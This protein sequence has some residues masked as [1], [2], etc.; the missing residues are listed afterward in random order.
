M[1][2]WNKFCENKLRIFIFKLQAI[3]DGFLLIWMWPS[4]IYPTNLL[5]QSKS[6]SKVKFHA[7]FNTEFHYIKNSPREFPFQ[8]QS[9]YFIFH[10]IF[11]ILNI[12]F[13]DSLRI[14][15]SKTSHT[16]LLAQRFYRFFSLNEPSAISN[17]NLS[18]KK[19]AFITVVTKFGSTL[20]AIFSILEVIYSLHLEK[21]DKE[22]SKCHIWHVKVA[23]MFYGWVHYRLVTENNTNKRLV[24]LTW[25]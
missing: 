4:N 15:I 6:S 2:D 13:S 8:H 20:S 17:N 14:S 3:H 21:N 19:F 7:I 9:H 22:I 12:L 5:I 25:W 23:G 24:L 10:L 1:K 16:C 11:K 18:Q